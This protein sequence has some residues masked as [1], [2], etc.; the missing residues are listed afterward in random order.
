[1]GYNALLV[2]FMGVGGSEGKQTTIGYYEAEEV[3]TVAD[4]LQKKGEKNIIL[5]GTSMGA[6]AVMRAVSENNLAVNSLILECPFGSMLKTVQARFNNMNVPSFPM[7]NLL[8]F[9]G[10]IQNNFDAFSHNPALYAKNISVPTLLLYGEKDLEVSKE[11][12]TE[13][14]DN[15]HGQKEFKSYPLAGHENYLRLYDKEWTRDVSEFLDNALLS[16]TGPNLTGAR[17]KVLR[18]CK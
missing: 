4:Y 12:I 17:Q 1:M 10:G 7:A 16:P 5:Y 3:K 8:V 11:E 13:I 9:W 14:F 18:E 2:D 15:L 6:A